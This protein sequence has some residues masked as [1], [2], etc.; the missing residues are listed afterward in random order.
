MGS[1]L[2]LWSMPREAVRARQVGGQGG[3]AIADQFADESRVSRTQS[4]RRSACGD[5]NAWQSPDRAEHRQMV[6]RL[7]RNSAPSA[8][9]LQ[10][11]DRRYRVQG[12]G[13]VADD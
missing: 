4:K 8:D 1:V 2:L 6:R 7:G 10:L 5:E 11:G 12:D 3:R 9:E 13:S